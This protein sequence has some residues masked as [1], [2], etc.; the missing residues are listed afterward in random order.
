[1]NSIDPDPASAGLDAGAPYVS[2]LSI[3][4]IKSFAMQSMNQVRV[5]AHGAI[6]DRE[7][8]IVD[9]EGKVTSLYKTGAFAG[10]RADVD[11]TRD[12]LTIRD[13]D[14]GVWAG[15]VVLGR[16]VDVDHYGLRT[17]RAKEVEGPWSAMLSDLAGE[18]V[19]L[20]RYDA[21]GSGADVQ[22]LTL[23]SDA[24]VNHL[25]AESGVEQ[26]DPRRFRMLMGIGG[27]VPHAEDEWNGRRVRIGDAVLEIGGP[28]PRCA[29]VRATRTPANATCRWSAPSAATAAPA[30]P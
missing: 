22:P 27:T 5:E 8:V 1:M 25:A 4:P 29:A 28:V 18:P 2:Y 21:A 14:D 10:L 26:V 3:A 13:R 24:T 23:L 19:R 9:E 17:A 6:G 16:N 30:T 12:V 15:D 7:F 20:A 11:H